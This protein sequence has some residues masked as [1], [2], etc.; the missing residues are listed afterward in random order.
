M[1]RTLCSAA[2]T[3]FLITSTTAQ[4]CAAGRYVTPGYFA[5][6]EVT[7]GVIFGS[8]TGVS[9]GNQTLRMDVYQPAGDTETLRPVVVVAFGGSFVGG[10]RA[11]VAPI[12]QAFARMG[13]VAVANDYRVGFFLPNQTTTT[14]AVMRGAH[15]MRACVRYLR[16]SVVEMGNPYGID[17]NR[18]IVGGVSAGAI[19]ALHAVYLD[20]ESEVPSV[21][22]SELP[23]LGGIEG[24]SGN[25]GF[26]SQAMA[27][28]SFSGCIGDTLWIEPGDKPCVS[29]H[30]TGDN[31]V[32]FNTSQVSVIGIPTG[33]SA[34]GSNHIHLRMDNLGLANCLKVYQANAH[35]GYLQSDQAN[36]LQFIADF[37]KPLVC[38]EE[39]LCLGLPTSVTERTST[40]PVAFPNPTNGLLN[41]QL[42]NGAQVVLHDISGREVL[43]LRLLPGLSTIDLGG[44]PDGVYLLRTIGE[45]AGVQ[46]VVKSTR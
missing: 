15:D 12:C 2:C 17:T 31:V 6:V 7:S 24:N 30:E 23:A 45:G 36:A 26:S 28:Y 4:E 19:S 27:V 1:T 21:L 8:N 18:I 20:K 42:E 14:R 3:F 33:L 46:R 11:D 44:L 40:P 37:L 39:P 34:S 32:P 10:N 16:R 13:Y 35:V 25:P 5:D 41:I 9:G 38:G 22:T 43:A 29:I